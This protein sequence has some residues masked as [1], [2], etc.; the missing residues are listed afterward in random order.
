M[1]PCV[2]LLT[3]PSHSMQHSAGNHRGAYLLQAQSVLSG[4]VPRRRGEGDSSRRRRRQGHNSRSRGMA[5]RS[6][7]CWIE[8]E[9]LLAVGLTLP[10]LLLDVTPSNIPQ[11]AEEM[12]GTWRLKGRSS[13]GG[14]APLSCFCSPVRERR[15]RGLPGVHS[16][17]YA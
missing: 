1:W 17:L 13:S 10:Q 12:Y 7:P 3:V 11:I 6:T 9:H 8:R 2:L 14:P 5:L 4:W 15:F 16:P